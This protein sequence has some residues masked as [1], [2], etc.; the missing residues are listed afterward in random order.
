M[1]RTS[2]R[3]NTSGCARPSSARSNWKRLSAE[4]WSCLALLYEHEHAFGINTQPGSLERLRRAAERAVGIDPHSQTAWVAMARAEVFAR[5]MGALNLAVDRVIAINPL[6][7]DL[8]ALAGFYLSLAGGHERGAA[9]V[10]TALPRK[11]QHPSWYRLT[12]F[13]DHFARGRYEEALHE[14]QLISRTQ[15]PLGALAGAAVA[16]ML[17]RAAEARLYLAALSEIHPRCRRRR[18]RARCGRCGSWTSRSSRRCST[19][20]RRRLR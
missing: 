1:S 15:M 3:T 9:I 4:G 5:D 8:V 12:L 13:N 19:D 20:S 18:A 17:G 2:G 11:A 6:N 7:A 14:V 10:R 16:G